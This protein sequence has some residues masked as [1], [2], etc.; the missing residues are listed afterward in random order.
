[1]DQK[2]FSWEEAIK[3]GWKAT[4]DHLGFFIKAMI[5]VFVISISLGMVTKMTEKSVPV[6]SLITNLMGVFFSLLFGVGLIKIYLK[7]CDGKVPEL[8]DLLSGI[9]PGLMLR[10]LAA[11]LFYS[12]IFLGGLILLIIPGIIW[13]MQ[14]QFC[15][16]LVID[17]GLG[18]I[19]AL[20][21]SSGI[22]KGAKWDL[23]ILTC[24]SVLINLAGLLALGI[25]LFI[26][27]PLTM[28]ALTSVYRKLLS[29]PGLA[30][31]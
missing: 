12:L 2:K 21:K 9:T 24:L 16:Y 17:K 10:Y 4:L 19:A 7:I 15:T 5:I 30:V 22:T 28:L 29:E 13:L 23:F 11:A 27:M 18:P 26:T 3:L 6:L 31:T 20:K 25:G 1:M 8:R 14:F